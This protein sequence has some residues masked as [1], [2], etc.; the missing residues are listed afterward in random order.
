MSA[1]APLLEHSGGLDEHGL[2]V[3]L[4]NRGKPAAEDAGAPSQPVFRWRDAD[5]L[6]CAHFG[7]RPQGNVTDAIATGDPNLQSDDQ[8]REQA[9]AQGWLGV[10]AKSV[11]GRV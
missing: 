10:W 8:A 11:G 7:L 3:R 6:A 2:P 5:V 9:R 1:L 4:S